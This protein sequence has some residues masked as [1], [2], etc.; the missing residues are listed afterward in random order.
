VCCRPKTGPGQ[1]AHI[2]VLWRHLL[3]SGD[4]AAYSLP[5]PTDMIAIPY[6]TGRDC[7][8]RARTQRKTGDD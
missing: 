3:R 8:L 1:I 7:R 5:V 2:R 4:E 6:R